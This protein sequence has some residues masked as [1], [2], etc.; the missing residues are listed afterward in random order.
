MSS[1]LFPS[2]SVQSEEQAKIAGYIAGEFCD[3]PAGYAK[4]VLGMPPDPWQVDVM[5]SVR[6][7]RRTAVGACHGPGKSWLAAAIIKWWMATRPYPR[8]RATANTERQIMS[9]LWKELAKV[10][11]LAKDHDLYDLNKT[12]FALKEMPDLWWAQA[13]AWSENN[14]EAFAG[15]HEENVLYIFDEASSIPD[16]IWETAQG[17]MTHPNARWL[18]L[19]NR[20][21]NTGRFNECFGKNKW[22]HGDTDTSLWHAYTVSAFDSPRVSKEYI[23]EIRRE[24]GEGSDPWRVRVLGLPP[25]QEQQQFIPLDLLEKALHMNVSSLPHE[26]RILG[27]DVARFGDD[28]SVL[29]E[30]KGRNAKVVKV[31][32]GQDTMAVTGAVM[33]TLN[34]AKDDPYDYV[35]VDVIGVGS[36]VVDRLNEQNIDVIAVNVGEK[37]RMEDCKNLRAELWKRCKE[38]LKEGHVTEDFRDDLIGPQYSYDS[39]GRLVIERKEDMKKRGLASSDIADA[40]CLTFFPLNP[41]RRRHARR[42]AQKAPRPRWAKAVGVR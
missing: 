11:R 12:S 39:S 3:D 26:P 10:H 35:C 18:V 38:W 24:Y 6:D 15:L 16:I 5:E 19:G 7:N 31:L 2:T 28:R 29:V 21:R 36:G 9:I 23:E 4:A 17:A 14:P 1:T 33:D 25:M 37:P 41:I 30:R 8:I 32:R 27:V 34:G 20:T 13:I 40:L 42:P 22:Q